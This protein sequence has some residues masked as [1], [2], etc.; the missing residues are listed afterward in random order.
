MN[1]FLFV[2]LH[3]IGA[4]VAYSVVS[5]LLLLFISWRHG[6]VVTAANEEAALDLGIPLA[7]L[8]NDEHFTRTMQYAATRSSNELLRNRL[9]DLCGLLTT[10]WN[11]LAIAAVV[12][13]VI[14]VLW[15][16]GTD[17]SRDVVYLWLTIPVMIGM[18]L[19]GLVFSYACKLLTGRYPGQARLARKELAKLAEARHRRVSS[20]G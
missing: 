13:L 14:A 10:A 11:W 19:I 18:W 12:G 2:T 1:T 6:Q 4:V 16:M 20:K 8:D 5:F 17:T 9:S 15:N 3:V 7:D